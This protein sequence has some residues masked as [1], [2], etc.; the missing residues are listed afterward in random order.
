MPVL[1]GDSAKS[2][3]GGDFEAERLEEDG[4]RHAGAHK[5][6]GGR[7]AWLVLR[8]QGKGDAR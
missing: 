8:V 3:T 2:T 5:V 6:S 1:P 4:H 7:K